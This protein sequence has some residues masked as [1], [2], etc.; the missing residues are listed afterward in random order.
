MYT[1]GQDG[2]WDC[3]MGTLT[4]KELEFPPLRI[5]QT[6]AEVQLRVCLCP[7]G[8]HTR[9]RSSPKEASEKAP[10]PQ[11]NL[12]GCDTRGTQRA[13]A[14]VDQ[15]EKRE[16]KEDGGGLAEEPEL[17]PEVSEGQRSGTGVGKE[18]AM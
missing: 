14:E 2:S 1:E 10:G 6:C 4:T 9:H 8:G 18:C 16:A 17:W 3:N 13:M 7:N 15:M 5:P 11:E 12:A